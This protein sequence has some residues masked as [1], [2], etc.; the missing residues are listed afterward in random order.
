MIDQ[1]HSEKEQMNFNMY[2]F[3]C[4]FRNIPDVVLE[5]VGSSLEKAEEEQADNDDSFN[6]DEY[7]ET[8]A[9]AS[10]PAKEISEKF[11]QGPTAV[12]GPS[13]DEWF[14]RTTVQVE[15]ELSSQ[16]IKSKAHTDNQV[17]EFKQKATAEHAAKVQALEEQKNNFLASSKERFA[18]QL[19]SHRKEKKDLKNAEDET[20]QNL[21]TKFDE[22]ARQKPDNAFV[23]EEVENYSRISAQKQETWLREFKKIHEADLEI[24]RKVQLDEIEIY[25]QR[26]L[27]QGKEKVRSDIELE[28]LQKQLSITK[29]QQLEAHRQ[30][31]KY[32]RELAIHDAEA[33]EELKL[34]KMKILSLQRVVDFKEQSMKAQVDKMIEDCVENRRKEDEARFEEEKLAAQNAL[35]RIKTVNKKNQEQAEEDDVAHKK[36]L[37]SVEEKKRQLM[38]SNDED[39]TESMKTE[40]KRSALIV[41]EMKKTLALHTQRQ[42]GIFDANVPHCKLELMPS[43][44]EHLQQRRLQLQQKKEKPPG[45]DGPVGGASEA[46]RDHIGVD[47][48]SS[49]DDE[50]QTHEEAEDENLSLAKTNET[51][52]DSAE[53]DNSAYEAS[54]KT[55]DDFAETDN[56]THE[57]SVKTSDDLAETNNSTHEASI[58]TSKESAETDNSTCEAPIDL[59]GLAGG[60]TNSPIDSS[61]E[62]ENKPTNTKCFKTKASVKMRPKESL[63]E[64]E[65]RGLYDPKQ[66]QLMNNAVIYIAD[67]D[68][69]RAESVLT[70]VPFARYNESCSDNVA[71]YIADDDSKQAESALADDVPLARLKES[72]RDNAVVYIGDDVLIRA[73]SALADDVPLARLKESCR[74]N[75]VVYIGDDD[76]KRAES[77]LADNV[78]LARFKESCTARVRSVRL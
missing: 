31:V 54:V 3:S 12:Q 64:S 47:T 40:E 41:E 7:E 46:N 55:S 25:E 51:S 65:L 19:Q 59:F 28:T 73:E 45:F 22:L 52:K 38:Q 30:K 6:D 32:S 50:N 24:W 16:A 68:S 61:K 63:E 56:S 37:Q 10:A 18:A 26:R 5:K 9:E 77:A 42:I 17:A 29:A 43:R 33:E 2:V 1:L 44:I 75:A 49:T 60:G 15:D 13:A 62:A 69:K 4:L 35:D 27:E 70:D 57:A 67:E 36:Y 8:M 74:D 71:V 78:P 66:R 58:K 21:H 20:L 48:D 23:Q 76:L 11:V 34:T 14:R 72:C 39:V 53:T